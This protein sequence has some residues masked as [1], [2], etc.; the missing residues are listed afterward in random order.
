[1]GLEVQNLSKSTLF[2]YIPLSMLFSPLVGKG[3]YLPQPTI[4]EMG[5]T[6]PSPNRKIRAN[7]LEY[8]K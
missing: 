5:N 3:N 8:Y 1:M 7:T 4:S 2:Y 6:D